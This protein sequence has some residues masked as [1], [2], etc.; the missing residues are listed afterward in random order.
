MVESFKA[1]IAIRAMIAIT[2]PVRAHTNHA[3]KNVPNKVKDGDVYCAHALKLNASRGL[4]KPAGQPLNFVTFCISKIFH[5]KMRLGL[6]LRVSYV[7]QRR[8]FILSTR[9]VSKA[10]F[11]SCFIFHHGVK[12]IPEMTSIDLMGC[13]E[14][15]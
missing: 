3:G 13:R 6:R 5:V 10:I 14:F 9:F 8:D 7:C 15:F 1:I 2:T 11:H 12:Y 4:A